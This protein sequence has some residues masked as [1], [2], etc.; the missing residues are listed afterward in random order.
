MKITK[1]QLIRL[2]VESVTDNKNIINE[3][4][5]MES[6]MMSTLDDALPKDGKSI[7]NTDLRSLLMQVIQLIHNNDKSLKSAIEKVSQQK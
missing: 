3:V 4:S 6:Y 1:S 5:D 2:C 7:S